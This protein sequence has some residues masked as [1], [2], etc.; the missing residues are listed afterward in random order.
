VSAARV[1]ITCPP[2]IASSGTYIDRLRAEGLEVVLPDVVQ[3]LTEDELIALIGDVEGVIAGDDPFSARVLDNA[4]RLRILVRWG[5]GID[6]VDLN[7]ARVRGIRVVNTPGAFGEE[8]ADV[9]IGYLVLLARQLHRVDQAVRE[10]TWLK[11]QGRSLAG[12]VT[13]IV[14]LGTIGLA[15]ARRAQAMRMHVIGYDIDPKACR[16]SETAGTRVDS[17]DNVV[18]GSDVLILCASLTPANRRVIND[19]AF[20]RMRPGSF[21]INVS[22]GGLVDE[23]AL[24]DALS[25][26]QIA[27]AALDVFEREPLPA[28]SPL[29]RFDQVI[30]GSHNASNTTEA[31]QRVNELAIDHL[32]R[33]LSEVRR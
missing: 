15:V 3:Q 27:G 21:L 28:D 10:G 24:V 11:P 6:N 2:A 23:Q 14:G 8:V 31:V 29:R 1:L 20:A 33:G 26:G 13:G 4:P 22:R 16:E 19:A 7:A 32:L 5:V 30:L 17:L 9:V 18:A 25:T 12:L